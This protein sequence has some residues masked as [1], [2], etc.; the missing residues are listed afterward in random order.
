MKVSVID[1][2]VSQ[3]G[4]GLMVACNYFADA[5]LFRFTL[6]GHHTHR[7]P[8]PSEGLAHSTVYNHFRQLS[9]DLQSGALIFVSELP[10]VILLFTQFYFK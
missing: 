7:D 10:G 5:G 4:V 9:V 2:L 3:L 1:F 8:T 6:L